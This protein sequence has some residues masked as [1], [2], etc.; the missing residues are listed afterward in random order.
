MFV[1]FGQT[2]DSWI[3]GNDKF[4][5]QHGMPDHVK[6]HVEK[7]TISAKDIQWCSVG[8]DGILCIAKWLST[9]QW[10]IEPG[11]CE[12]FFSQTENLKADLNIG[13]VEHITFASGGGWFVRYKN[14]TVRL[15]MEG[16]FPSVFHEIA[17]P[18]MQTQGSAR[19]NLQES[20]I[21]NVFFGADD[22]IL[23]QHN[24]STLPSWDTSPALRWKG[25]PANLER[26]LKELFEDDWVLSKRTNLCPWNKEY[27]YVEWTKPFS[28]EIKSLYVLPP[29][30]MLPALFVRQMWEGEYPTSIPQAA[31]T[32]S[33]KGKS[34]PPALPPRNNNKSQPGVSVEMIR[35]MCGDLFDHWSDSQDAMNGAKFKSFCHSVLPKQD[36]AKIWSLSDAD[37]N[38]TFSRDEFTIAV[39]LIMSRKNG[40]NLPSKVPLETVLKSREQ[41]DSLRARDTFRYLKDINILCDLCKEEITTGLWDDDLGSGMDALNLNDT[42]PY[43]PFLDDDDDDDDEEH[44]KKKGGNDK[45]NN[46]SEAKPSKDLTEDEKSLRG[47]L[48]SSIVKENPNVKWEDVAGLETAK[49]ELQEAVILPAKFP[50]LFSGKRKPRR[51]ILLYGPPG[52]GKSYLAKAVATEA[53]ST[54]FSISSSD[55]V[56]K[57]HGE[58]E[59]LIKTLFDLARE[60]KPSV[61]F[62]DEIDALCGSRDAPGHN[63]LTAGLKTEIMV[64]MDG[65]GRDNEGVLVLAATNLPWTLDPAIRR[66]LQR[67]IYIALPDEPARTEMFKIHVGETPCGL[68]PEHYAA[69]GK[70]TEGLSGSDIGNAVQD[71]LMQPVKKVSSSKYWKKVMHK[72][73]EKLTPC[74][75]DDPGAMPMN[76]R[77]VPAS[78]LQESIVVAEDFFE[79][80]QNVKPTVS[81]DEIKKYLEW[82]ELY[83]MEGA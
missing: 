76:W 62:I 74:K 72:G 69:L 7:G 12:L 1:L 20:T 23:I 37:G 19:S 47:Q 9:D 27:Y 4:T 57:W 21:S 82:T 77:Q 38:G 59:R 28:S 51:G 26:N 56:S 70:Q 5:M 42:N 50:K 16:I 29:H 66:R 79:V 13:G 52:T 11:Q 65:V 64:Q 67:K 81:L 10:R 78:K 63:P 48:A 24:V 39:Y 3:I 53:N 6:D 75:P 32:T 43:N 83:G 17:S 55:V 2:T 36:L 44:G 54:L 60:N 80:L 25:L 31:T 71:A 14:G 15:S 45:N 46:K 35:E 73:A 41:N 49:E 58:S 8:Q 22:A 33:V 18:N 34:E 68:T 40:S 30:R 61:V